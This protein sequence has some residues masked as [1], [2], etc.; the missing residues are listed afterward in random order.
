MLSA[1]PWSFDGNSDWI[2]V[3][4]SIRTPSLSTYACPSEHS[5]TS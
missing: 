5:S 3:S 2:P 1:W 4:G